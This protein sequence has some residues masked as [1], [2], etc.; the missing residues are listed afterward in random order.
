LYM[1]LEYQKSSVQ[2]QHKSLEETERV[3]RLIDARLTEASQ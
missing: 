1:K 3:K 2:S